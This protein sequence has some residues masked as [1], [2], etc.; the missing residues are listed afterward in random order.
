MLPALAIGMGALSLAS[1]VGGFFGQSRQAKQQNA[2]NAAMAQLQDNYRREQNAYQYGAWAQDLAF[3][4]ETLEY[5]KAEFAKQTAWANAALAAVEKNRDADAFTLAVR[6][7]EENIA[8]TF[9]SQ[10]VAQQG[11]TA[12]AA[13]KAK[14][15][16]VEG[17]SVDA[18]LGDVLRQEGEAQTVIEMNR[19][20]TMRQ[21]A[22]EALAA[23]A[24]VDQQASQIAS[25]VK[26]YSPEAPLKAPR[27]APPAAPAQRVNGPSGFA[28]AEGVTN[29]IAAGFGTY[30]SLSGRTA[31][32][33]FDGLTT[34][35]QRRFS[36]GGGGG[37]E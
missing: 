3:A 33:T 13:F 16:G 8:A 9:A 1:S 19:S 25:A 28:L 31:K 18:V 23:D 26:T 15:R 2:Y 35:A 20:A 24:Q 32:Q 14:D 17:A 30:T 11:R 6:G 27:D 37:D 29:A 21:L 7:V 34:W 12:R 4:R 36:F 22:R 10:S 5:S